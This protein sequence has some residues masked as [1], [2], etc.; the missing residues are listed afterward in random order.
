[1]LENVRAN[2]L[3]P[4]QYLTVRSTR[5]Q[6]APW[7]KSF[8]KHQI[9]QNQICFID[10][11]ASISKI[12]RTTSLVSRKKASFQKMYFPIQKY[13]WNAM[14]LTEKKSNCI[15]MKIFNFLWQPHESGK[16]NLCFP[17]IVTVIVQISVTLLTGNKIR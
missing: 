9:K 14:K 12:F 8:W 10:I 15:A 2:V 16:Y 4:C 11:I 1:M 6:A 13:H 3:K 5:E 17:F 7:H